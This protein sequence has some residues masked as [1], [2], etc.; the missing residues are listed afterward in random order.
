MRRIILLFGILIIGLSL[1]AQNS[2]W[3]KLM[4]MGSRFDISVVAK[5]SI[6]GNRFIDL[7]VFEIKRIENMIS[8]WD[9]QSQTAAINKN[10]GL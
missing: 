6:E 4:L 5:D 9:I 8:S 3:R 7:A 10:E 2:Y 1:H